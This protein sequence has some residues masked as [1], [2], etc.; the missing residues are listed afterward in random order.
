MSVEFVALLTPPIVGVIGAA[1]EAGWQLGWVEDLQQWVARRYE[2]A[3]TSDST[4]S[5]WGLMPLL[6]PYHTTGR[7]VDRW[8][9]G[10]V[11]TGLTLILWLYLTEAVALLAYWATIVAF[12]LVV[13]AA[14]IYVLFKLL[15]IMLTPEH[16]G[17]RSEAGVRERLE[18]MREQDRSLK[19]DWPFPPSEKYETQ[20]AKKFGDEFGR[21]DEDG[22]IYSGGPFPL[23]I[24]YI[25]EDGTIYDTRGLT[26]EKLG[27]ITED[28]EVE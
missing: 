2:H 11:A 17:G 27:Q 22:S 28:G 21:I 3:S 14:F 16:A 12:A 9:G 4:L 25:D 19:H 26:R 1:V 18:T 7:L 24:G 20:L 10:V 8:A 5:R 23:K 6:W 15:G 13:A